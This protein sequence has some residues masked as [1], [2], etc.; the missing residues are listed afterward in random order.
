MSPFLDQESDPKPTS[1]HDRRRKPPPRSDRPCFP[2]RT[3]LLPDGHESSLVTVPGE[4]RA[5]TLARLDGGRTVWRPLTRSGDPLSAARA[6]SGLA[7]VGHGGRR[8]QHSGPPQATRLADGPTLT[9]GGMLPSTSHEHP[10]QR[11]DL[12]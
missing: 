2:L 11:A 8:N 4:Q 12:S 6:A 3:T 1:D 9:R 10:R 7:E 5:R